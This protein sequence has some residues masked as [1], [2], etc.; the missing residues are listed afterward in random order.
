MIR[1]SAGYIKPGDV[2]IGWN[3]SLMLVLAVKRS[4]PKKEVSLTYL[5]TK[6]SDVTY[7]AWE[8]IRVIV[9]A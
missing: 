8:S 9:N 4:N 6:V 1:Q 2:M 5:S 3:N 7:L